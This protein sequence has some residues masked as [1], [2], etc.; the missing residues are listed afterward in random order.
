M[1]GSRIRW[2][3]VAIFAAVMTVAEVVAVQAIAR[4]AQRWLAGDTAREIQSAGRTVA[5]VVSGNRREGRKVMTLRLAESGDAQEL[6][7][8]KCRAGACARRA[9]AAHLAKAILNRDEI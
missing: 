8:L 6:Q 2:T 1:S 5:E 4:D 7:A 9:R 3:A